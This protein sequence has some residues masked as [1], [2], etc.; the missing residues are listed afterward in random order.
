MVNKPKTVD[1]L[2]QIP[3]RHVMAFNAVSAPAY[4]GHA[5]GHRWRDSKGE[6]EVIVIAKDVE[7]LTHFNDT[8]EL[9]A[10]VNQ[11]KVVPV[12]MAHM[13]SL[14]VVNAEGYSG[15]TGGSIPVAT[16]VSKKEE[17]EEW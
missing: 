15:V 5:V 9:E 3:M 17:S 14:R 12:G 16:P 10:K 1:P 4:V 11:E 8:F 6:H 7:T 2:R 13:R